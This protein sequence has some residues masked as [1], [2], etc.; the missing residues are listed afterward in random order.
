MNNNI[1]KLNQLNPLYHIYIHGDN[2]NH[3]S[4]CTIPR[5]VSLNTIT[6]TFCLTLSNNKKKSWSKLQLNYLTLP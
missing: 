6:P 3:R 2:H 1:D 4:P 5:H